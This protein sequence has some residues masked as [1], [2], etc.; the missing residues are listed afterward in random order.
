MVNFFKKRVSVLVFFLVIFFVFS[1]LV[2]ENVSATLLNPPSGENRGDYAVNDIIIL[3]INIATWLLGITGSLTLLAF[4]YGGVLFL[5]SAGNNETV[6]KAKKIIFGAIVGLII[7][8]LSYT[9]INF[10]MTGMGYHSTE[11]GKWN[12]ISK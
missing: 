4:I 8:F 7:V 2:T 12:E 1:F 5:I 11:F 3:L 6:A 9:I 10:L